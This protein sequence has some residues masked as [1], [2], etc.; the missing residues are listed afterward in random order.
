MT[1]IYEYKDLDTDSRNNER[2]LN[3]LRLAISDMD[4][5]AQTLGFTRLLFHSVG[6]Q[7]EGLFNTLRILSLPELIALSAETDGHFCSEHYFSGLSFECT[8]DSGIYVVHGVDICSE[9]ELDGEKW[10]ALEMGVVSGGVELPIHS[11]D[12]VRNENVFDP[13]GQY[14]VRVEPG[15]AAPTELTS[16]DAVMNNDLLLARAGTPLFLEK[17]VRNSLKMEIPFEMQ[18]SSLFPATML[19]LRTTGVRA[20]VEGKYFMGVPK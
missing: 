12:D 3:E 10:Y 17:L 19:Q 11:V 8:K 9:G 14:I 16:V 13:F 2:S 1:K 6:R 15:A 20:S 7:I 4:E 5:D 18:Y